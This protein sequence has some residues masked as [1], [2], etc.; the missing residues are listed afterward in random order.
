M[1]TKVVMSVGGSSIHFKREKNACT[2]KDIYWVLE[3]PYGRGPGPPSYGPSS[4]Q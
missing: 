1:T 3:G 4:T 2:F